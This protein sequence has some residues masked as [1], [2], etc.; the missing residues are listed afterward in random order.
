MTSRADAGMSVL[1]LVVA[2]GIAAGL[3]VVVAA[4]LPRPAAETG[5]GA[6]A[7]ATFLSEARTR[8]ILSGEAGAV[9]VARQSMVLGDKRIDWGSELFVATAAASL[10]TDYRLVIYPDG[11]YSGA[12][13]YVRSG[14]GK[15]LIPGTFRSGPA[16]E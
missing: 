11:S 5:T 7:I 15:Q 16:D 14:G 4:S 13:L 10:P 9:T 1:E 2:L 6:K 8:A 12:P 3:L